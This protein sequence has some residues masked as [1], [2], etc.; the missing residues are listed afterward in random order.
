[1]RP[2]VIGGGYMLIHALLMQWFA[3]RYIEPGTSLEEDLSSVEQQ[4]A[5]VNVEDLRQMRVRR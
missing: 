3:A 5:R 4:R 1:M 2:P